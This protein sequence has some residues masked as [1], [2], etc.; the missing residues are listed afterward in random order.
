MIDHSALKD[1][2]NND[3]LALG[4]QPHVSSGD[5]QGVADLL[6]A[7]NYTKTAPVPNTVV[8]KW[9]AANGVL[10]A[11]SDTAASEAS[12]VRAICIATLKLLD[13]LVAPLK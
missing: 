11:V 10:A 1:E 3:P 9:I 12:P 8:L 2:I 4:F 5:D 13:N 7:K 6:N